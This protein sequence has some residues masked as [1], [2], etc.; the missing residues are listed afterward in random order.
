MN[1][2]LAGGFSVRPKE[3]AHT[4]VNRRQ[5]PNRR[6]QASR[7][8]R[9][10]LNLCDRDGFLPE[11]EGLGVVA[12]DQALI[13]HEDGYA[14]EPT[15]SPNALPSTSAS[16]RCSR[17]RTRSPSAKHALRTSR[18]MSMASSTVFRARRFLATISS[19][20]ATPDTRAT[21]RAALRG[22][23]ILCGGYS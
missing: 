23:D 12:A 21:I 17:I 14:P 2:Q 11:S 20:S 4:R 9:G 1:T 10:S 7:R 18:W 16:W 19:P 15:W 8:G 5:F 22:G 3:V 6:R 13:P